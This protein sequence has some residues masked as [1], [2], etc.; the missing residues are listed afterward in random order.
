NKKN[1]GFGNGNDLENA[2]D[3]ILLS[4]FTPASVVINQRMEILQFRGETNLYLAHAPGIATL[5]ILKMARPE[6]SFEL[7]NA[8]A[9]AFKTKKPVDKKSIEM[10]GGR[11]IV[12]LEVLPLDNEFVEPMLLIVFTEQQQEEIAT[13]G[14]GKR[15]E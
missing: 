13:Q 12:S 3:S 1:K 10:N 9:K 4:R 7:R 6:I 11:N 5:D 15:S 8:I 2:I 14:K